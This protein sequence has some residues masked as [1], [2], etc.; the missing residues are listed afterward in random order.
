MI[1][2]RLVQMVGNLLFS[3]TGF[4][5]GLDL[6]RSYKNLLEL[7]GF[8]F[9]YLPNLSDLFSFFFTEFLLQYI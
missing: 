1:Y 2:P 7:S 6:L 3:S 8:I 5:M 4:Y 9:Q